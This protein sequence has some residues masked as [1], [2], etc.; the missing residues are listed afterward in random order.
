MADNRDD[1]TRHKQPPPLPDHL[2]F[3]QLPPHTLCGGPVAKYRAGNP[4]RTLLY[5]LPGMGGRVNAGLGE[6]LASRGGLVEGREESGDFR[7]YDFQTQI[8]TVKTDLLERHWNPSARVVANSYGAYLL[9]H[10]L[11]SLA[12]FP[13][14]M[15][16]LSP[17][18]GAF[19][20]EASLRS[21]VPPRADRLLKQA[22]AGQYPAPTRCEIHVGS[23]DWQSNPVAVTRFGEL[24]GIRV[25]VVPDAGH[26]LPKDYV[27]RV[28]NRFFAD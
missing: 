1:P 20:D 4:A 28:L 26:A 25:T 18:V 11:A 17:I 15:L 2:E 6:A 8:D 13:G 10:A 21:F 23:E 3:P 22:A 5:Y 14:K 7:Q 24:L 19:E 9:L 16:L 27:A 12:P